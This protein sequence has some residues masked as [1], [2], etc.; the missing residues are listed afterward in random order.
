[1]LQELTGRG[2]RVPDDVAIVGYDDIEFAR[3]PLS[4]CLRSAN[5]GSIWANGGQLLLVF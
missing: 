5:R 4:R 1:M 3:R 2:L